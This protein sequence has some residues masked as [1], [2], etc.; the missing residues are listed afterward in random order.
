MAKENDNPSTE[1]KSAKSAQTSVVP[2]TVPT[3]TLTAEELAAKKA[4]V[5]ARRAARARIAKFVTG[6]KAELGTLVDDI[7]LFIGKGSGRT[8]RSVGVNINVQIRSAFLAATDHVLSEMDIFKTF[9]IG[10][11]EMVAVTRKLILVPNPEDRIWI[12]F[13]EQAELYRV[14]GAGAEAPTGWIGYLPAEARQL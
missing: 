7:T 11:P 3:V 5:E 9:H 4:K 12:E 13:D 8:S 1:A 14:K 6:N 2:G 10:R